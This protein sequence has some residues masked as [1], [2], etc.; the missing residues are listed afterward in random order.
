MFSI[1]T[2]TIE[3]LGAC[4]IAAGIGLCFGLGAALIAGG[5]LILTGSFLATR[6]TDEGV[7]E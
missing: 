3:I 4:M 1:I 7:I 2:T 5:A 6:A